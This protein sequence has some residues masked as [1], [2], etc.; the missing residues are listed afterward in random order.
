MTP[1]EKVGARGLE[2]PTSRTRTVRATGLRYAPTPKGIIPESGPIL[3]PRGRFAIPASRRLRDR[4]AHGRTQRQN[5][6]QPRQID[7]HGQRHHL[8]EAD[9]L[10]QHHR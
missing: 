9:G 3:Q 8:G 10:G 6:R 5:S 7:E 2:P 4:V 1:C